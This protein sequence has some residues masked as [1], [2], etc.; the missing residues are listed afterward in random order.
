MVV[1]DDADTRDLIVEILQDDGYAVISAGNGREALDASHGLPG[2]P[3]IILLD[4]MMPIMNGWEF[5]DA[6]RHDPSLAGV[7]VLVLSADPTRQLAAQH[8]VAA[9]I[10]KPFDLSRLLRL[11]RAVTKAQ[12]A[13]A[14][15]V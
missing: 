1:E 12:S 14:Y 3:S 13:P 9:V 8:G 7:P 15:T 4:L 5:L 2:A 11:V 6:R 10:A